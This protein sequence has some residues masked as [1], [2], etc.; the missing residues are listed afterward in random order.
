MI[1]KIQ[2][3]WCNS[4]LWP[5]NE[6]LTVTIT[7]S[8]DGPGINDNEEW[9]VNLHSS[10]LQSSSLSIRCSFE[11]Y[12]GASLLGEVSHLFKSTVILFNG[13]GWHEF[14]KG[15]Y[16]VI[17]V[18]KYVSLPS[19]MHHSFSG[20]LIAHICTGVQSDCDTNSHVVLGDILCKN[21]NRCYYSFDFFYTIS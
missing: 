7:Q 14:G 10:T 17:K 11:S 16:L 3:I 5:V 19:T 9:R 6:T 15:P 13:P 12:L 18:R 8:Q 4:S 21:Q 2:S 1:I 20:L